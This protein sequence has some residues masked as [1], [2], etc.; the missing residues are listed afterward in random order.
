LSSSSDDASLSA[1]EEEEEANSLAYFFLRFSISQ[2]S[3][4]SSRL[5]EKE[6]FG[7]SHGVA[8]FEGMFEPSPSLPFLPLGLETSGAFPISGS[9]SFP[10]R[11]SPDIASPSG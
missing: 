8:G 6:S 5:L 9:T 7:D 2:R 11:T 3:F 4:N 10:P 1:L